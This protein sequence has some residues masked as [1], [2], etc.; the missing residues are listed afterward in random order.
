MLKS[1]VKKDPL[2]RD[3]FVFFD[4]LQK[5][6]KKTNSSLSAAPSRGEKIL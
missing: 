2:E 5:N 6:Q 3:E 1:W 4:F